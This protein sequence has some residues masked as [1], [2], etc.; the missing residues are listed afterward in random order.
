MKL[1][2]A[3]YIQEAFNKRSKNT[4]ITAERVLEE[5]ARLAFVNAKE[6]FDAEGNLKPI[7]ELPDEVTRSISG[8]DIGEVKI[9][10]DEDG[11][12]EELHRVKKVKFWDKRGSLELLARNLKLLTDKVERTDVPYD[13]FEAVRK[14]LESNPEQKAKML[15]ELTD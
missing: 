6:L 7:H 9:F 15:D 10:R 4:E 11:K 14:K 1:N 13:P 8:I 5:I 3:K 12:P 2:I